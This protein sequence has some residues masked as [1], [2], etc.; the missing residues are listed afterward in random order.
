M[1]S[2][3]AKPGFGHTS[4]AY[5]RGS[6]GPY[7]LTLVEDPAEPP[8][9]GP[10]HVHS[11]HRFDPRTGDY[12]RLADHRGLGPIPLQPPDEQDWVFVIRR[13]NPYDYKF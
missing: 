2:V 9:F 1:Y 3:L 11:V 12:E 6:P 7:L 8:E 5:M 13:L 10:Q 4:V